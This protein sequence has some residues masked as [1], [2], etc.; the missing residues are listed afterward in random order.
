V[1][2]TTTE[3]VALS[4]VAVAVSRS[5]DFGLAFSVGLTWKVTVHVWPPN[6]PLSQI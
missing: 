2:L 5:V 1:D 4:P 3:P 6:N